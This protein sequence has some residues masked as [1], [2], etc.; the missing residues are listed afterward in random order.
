MDRQVKRGWLEGP[1]LY[2]PVVIQPL[3]T[4]LK[5]EPTR[6]KVRNVLDGTRSGVNEAQ[7][8]LPVQYDL[9]DDLL[10]ELTPGCWQSKFD[11]A[12]AFL[13]WPMHAGDCDWF[14]VQHPQTH[15]YFRYRFLVFGS[16]QSPSVQQAWAR[17]IKSLVN[18]HGLKYCAPGSPAADYSLFKCT[19]AFL[20]DFHCRHDTSLSAAQ[21]AEQSRS[22]LC[23]LGQDLGLEIKESKT[24]GPSKALCYTGLLIDSVL[25]TVTITAER[26]HDLAASLQGLL[27]EHSEGDPVDRVELASLIGRC[28]FCAGVIPGSQSHLVQAS[29]ARNAFVEP[30]VQ[31]LSPKRQWRGVHVSVTHGLLTDFACWVDL[32]QTLPQRPYFLS[33]HPGTSGFWKGLLHDTDADID[34]SQVTVAGIPVFTTDA[35][36]PRG[37]GWFQHHRFSF[38]FSEEGRRRS[39]NWRE[40]SAIAHAL[41]L[42]GPQLA[43]LG[44]RV[45]VRTDNSAAVAAVNRTYSGSEDLNAV[46]QQVFS[47]AQAHGIVL[48]AR[49]IPG[50]HNKLANRLDALS[51]W[52]PDPQASSRQLRPV[53]FWD[54]QQ[55]IAGHEVDACADP[56]GGNWF[57][58]GLLV[59]CPECT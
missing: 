39:S 11:L 43:V 42:W 19:A 18:K 33:H 24:E 12:D 55:V 35:S 41:Q 10:P 13:H 14:G 40:L 8:H 5:Q 29:S 1:L 51:R 45:L 49:H 6:L 31:Y 15:E 57:L 58:P 16:S 46:A 59:S 34:A 36:G 21:A 26:A 50:I 20:D 9:L 52:R 37:G 56:T 2:K 23:F 28:Q 27:D 3:K 38:L 47:I 53:L 32:L 25:Q 7:A 4:I 30:T 48:A 22:V 44:P 54:L 17:T